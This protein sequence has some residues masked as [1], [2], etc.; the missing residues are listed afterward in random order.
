MQ[1]DQSAADWVR[2]NEKHVKEILSDR[3]KGTRATKKK[4]VSNVCTSGGGGGAAGAE[5]MEKG[6]NII[7]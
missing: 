1:T 7:T 5:A 4:N 2:A 3:A 6:P